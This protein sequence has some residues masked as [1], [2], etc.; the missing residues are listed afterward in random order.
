MN[1][2]DGLKARVS[3]GNAQVSI[4]VNV[5]LGGGVAKSDD[6]IARAFRAEER[7]SAAAGELDGRRAVDQVSAAAS[8]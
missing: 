4:L 6:E 3:S 2:G 8:T 5:S 7:C 1:Q